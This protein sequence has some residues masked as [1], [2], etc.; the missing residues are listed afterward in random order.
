MKTV[1]E[2]VVVDENL[3]LLDEKH[4]G[5]YVNTI[6]HTNGDNTYKG[7]RR[8]TEPSVTN[9]NEN[10][11]ALIDKKSQSYRD[12]NEEKQAKSIENAANGEPTPF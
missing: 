10:S 7:R 11:Q 5:I 6:S 9:T 4:K 1:E 12:L 2:E 8:A 3:Q